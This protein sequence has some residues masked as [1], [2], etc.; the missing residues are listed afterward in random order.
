MPGPQR[1]KTSVRGVHAA[2]LQKILFRNIQ[3][4]S[5]KIIFEQQPWI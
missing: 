1:T 5:D 2:N 3:L 4:F